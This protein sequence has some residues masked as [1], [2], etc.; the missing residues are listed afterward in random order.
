MTIKSI[1]HTL[2]NADIL[3]LVP[4]FASVNRPSLG[5]HILQACGRKQGYTIDILYT[6]LILA[7]LIGQDRYQKLCTSG[8]EMLVGE[9][10]FAGIAY[11]THKDYFGEKFE[12]ILFNLQD[13]SFD[14]AT[15]KS[16]AAASEAWVEGLVQTIAK[17]NY[18]I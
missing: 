11:G 8:S 1:S 12:Q 15:L 14:V 18:R 17:L 16:L 7:R 13:D 9:R 2:R 3:L 6:N 5:V 10:F 4:P